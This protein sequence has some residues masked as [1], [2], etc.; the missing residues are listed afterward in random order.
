MHS[1]NDVMEQLKSRV[2]VNEKEIM[3][4]KDR[5]AVFSKGNSADAEKAS[6]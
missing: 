4:L 5:L 6:F 1:Q 3:V 2:G